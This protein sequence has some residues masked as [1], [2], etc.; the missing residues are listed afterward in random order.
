[1]VKI[2]SSLKRKY[3]IR[4]GERVRSVEVDGKVMM[5]PVKNLGEMFGMDRANA[6]SLLDGIRELNREHRN[7]ARD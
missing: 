3:R 6:K 5:I 4:Q 2:H 1:M 7:K